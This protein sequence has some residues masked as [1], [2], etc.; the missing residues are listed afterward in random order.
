M[1]HPLKA[2]RYAEALDGKSYRCIFHSDYI[3]ATICPSEKVTLGYH[4]KLTFEKGIN[5]ELHSSGQRSDIGKL[6][7]TT[8]HILLLLLY[9]CQ[10][11]GL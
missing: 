2:R 5:I 6:S 10:K 8:R 3:N 4:W 1:M 11:D 7:R 9:G